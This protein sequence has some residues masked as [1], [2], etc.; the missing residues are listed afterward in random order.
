MINCSVNDFRNILCTG[1]YLL[2]YGLAACVDNSTDSQA[3]EAVLESSSATSEPSLSDCGN[4]L[5]FHLIGLKD[6]YRADIC[7]E[8]GGSIKGKFH[9]FVWK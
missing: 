4:L 1:L 3:E 7:L 9:I 2:V 8:D 6:L 5:H